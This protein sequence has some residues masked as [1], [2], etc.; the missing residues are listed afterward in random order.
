MANLKGGG[1]LPPRPSVALL[2][3]GLIGGFVGILVLSYLGDISG[4][5]WIMAPFGATCAILFAAP[6][7]PLAQPR[8]VIGG[9]LITS[10]VGLAALY[11]LG[12]SIL[13]MSLA[14][15]VAI[16]MMQFFR[17]VHP[18]AGA[19]PLIIILA[20]QNIIGLSFL[21]TP[22]LIGSV[23]LVLIAAVINNWGKENRWPVYWHGI[24]PLK[25]KDNS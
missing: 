9:H 2:L 3:K 5:P 17:A 4:V 18:P 21:V 8:N 20:G 12:D 1:S 23:M 15:G 25:R 19:N 22:V 14:V 11:G 6:T 7:S 16:M 24:S 13:V 10:S